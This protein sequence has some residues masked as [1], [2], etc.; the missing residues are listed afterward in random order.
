MLRPDIV[1]VSEITRQ[2]AL[3]EL[4]VPWE[5]RMEEAFERK[6]AKYEELSGECQSRGWRTRC[7]PIEVGCRGFV[8]HSV[9]EG[10]AH[11]KSRQEHHGRRRKSVKMAVDQA[12]RSVDHTS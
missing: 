2:V 5:D 3:L 8:G 10:T 4:T 6:R 1:L 11:Q 7:N 9:S 12:G